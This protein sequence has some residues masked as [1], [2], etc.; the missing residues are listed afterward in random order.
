MIFVAGAP[1]G[2]WRAPTGIKRR[3]FNHA[4]VVTT[5]DRIYDT[6]GVAINCRQ[7]NVA[8]TASHSLSSLR[9]SDLCLQLTQTLQTEIDTNKYNILPHYIHRYIVTLNT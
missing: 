2:Y 8:T 3:E 1:S 4:N 7:N 5:T 9:K 6:N